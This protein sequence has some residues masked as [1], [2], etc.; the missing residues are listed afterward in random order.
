MEIPPPIFIR[1]KSQSGYRVKKFFLIK[2]NFQR[3]VFEIG[4]NS[5]AQLNVCQGENPNIWEKFH[6]GETITLELLCPS[7][8][9]I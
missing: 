7:D 2:V 6:F 1:Q 4:I 9:Y 5:S 3:E 8:Y